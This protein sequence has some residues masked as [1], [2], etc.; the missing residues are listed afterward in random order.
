MGDANH[1]VDTPVVVGQER[2]SG[3]RRLDRILNIGRSNRDFGQFHENVSVASE[4]FGEDGAAL[5]VGQLAEGVETL[6]RSLRVVWVDAEHVCGHGGA[7]F[8]WRGEP[9]EANTGAR[10]RECGGDHV[11]LE[12]RGPWGWLGENERCLFEHAHH[13]AL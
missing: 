12:G 5:N 8:W 1:H 4:D 13:H 11:A 9:E 6:G 3:V 10:E 2:N 7:A